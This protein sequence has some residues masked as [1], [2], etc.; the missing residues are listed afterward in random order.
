[1]RQRECSHKHT[2]TI[3]LCL[4]AETI[5]ERLFLA[6]RR[7]PSQFP[8]C[9]RSRNMGGECASGHF[10]RKTVTVGTLL[11][12]QNGHTAEVRTLSA[13]PSRAP[14]MSL[15]ATVM[16]LFVVGLQAHAL[17]DRLHAE[18]CRRQVMCGRYSLKTDEIHFHLS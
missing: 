1:M 6:G 2:L 17:L 18:P 14:H 16:P 7:I 10:G 12:D 11:N 13:K 9:C 3:K 8:H 15:V 5:S 4:L